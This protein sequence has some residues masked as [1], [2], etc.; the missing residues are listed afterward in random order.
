MSIGT[1]IILDHHILVSC[2]SWMLLIRR[3]TGSIDIL[4]A[5]SSHFP[6]GK[7]KPG[8][9]CLRPADWVYCPDFQTCV[10]G[11]PVIKFCHSLEK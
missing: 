3:E 9:S 6:S 7:A 2:Q 8:T 10:A 11:V 4:L 5:T 1:R